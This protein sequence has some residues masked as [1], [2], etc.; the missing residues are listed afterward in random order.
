[1]NCIECEKCKI[2]GR[3]QIFG[4]ATAFK[5]LFSEDRIYHLKNLDRNEFIVIIYFIFIYFYLFLFIFI[6]FYL[7]LFIFI[8][9]YLFLF[10]FI[11]FLLYLFII[12]FIYYLFIFI[13]F[14]N[15]NFYLFIKI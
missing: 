10:I 5:I 6:Y 2:H 7:F 9:F 8:Y 14:I 15:K 3:M 1:M 11:L 4:I 12:Y 13:N